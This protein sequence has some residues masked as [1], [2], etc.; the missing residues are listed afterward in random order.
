MCSGYY[1]VL[2]YLTTLFNMLQHFSEGAEENN[3]E[4]LH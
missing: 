4:N 2:V 3:E 1:W